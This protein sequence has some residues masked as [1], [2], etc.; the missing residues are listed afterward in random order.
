MT[1]DRPSGPED[2]VGFLLWRTTLTWQRTIARAL[3]PLGL[4]HVQFVLLATVWWL[5]RADAV[6]PSQRQVAEQAATDVMMTSQVLRALERRALVTRSGDPDDARTKRVAVTAEGERLV[7]R[8][9]P[10]VEGADADVFG[11]PV[12]RRALVRALRDV[13]A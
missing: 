3:E 12:A 6:L 9:L 4:T 1:D 10:V 5:G 2:S 8:A 7:E 11:G 13:G